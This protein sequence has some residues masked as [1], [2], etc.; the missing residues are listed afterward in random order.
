MYFN[1]LQVASVHPHLTPSKGFGQSKYFND[2]YKWFTLKGKNIY[3]IMTCALHPNAPLHYTT[4]LKCYLFVVGGKKG[5]PGALLWLGPMKISTAVGISDFNHCP[6]LHLSY[7]LFSF[8]WKPFLFMIFVFMQCLLA[9]LRQR[10]IMFVW[11]WSAFHFYIMGY[12]DQ[13]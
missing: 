8:P 6:N 3:Y 11:S 9:N 4:R 10:L 7:Y 13:G 12:P 2:V 5:F 1:F